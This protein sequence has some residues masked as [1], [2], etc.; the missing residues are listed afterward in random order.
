MY[1]YGY[2]CE[3]EYDVGALQ[4]L[5]ERYA[6]EEKQVDI[7]VVRE[8][9]KPTNGPVSKSA[10]NMRTR[11]FQDKAVDLCFYF[12]DK[13]KGDQ[14]KLSHITEGIE[15]VDRN[16]LDIAIIGIPAPHFEAWLLCDDSAAKDL[17]NLQGDQALPFSELASNPKSRLIKLADK[18]GD[19]ILTPQEARRKLAEKV[20]I[21]ILIHNDPTFQSFVN[22]F[23]AAL[24]FLQANSTHVVQ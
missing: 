18:Y 23:N 24:A 16:M 19:E 9:C 7:E 15:S 20:N 3:G 12:S 1:K 13:D 4:T 6:L 14:D 8:L 21:R 2:I 5:I 10:V 11:L 17:F 22:S